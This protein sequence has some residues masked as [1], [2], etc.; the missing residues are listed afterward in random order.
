M[1]RQVPRQGL[2]EL[3]RLARSQ[4][5]RRGDIFAQPGERLPGLLAVV[6]G[7]VKLALRGERGE[8][9]ILRLVGPANTLARRCC[10]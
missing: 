1:F 4:E 9:R 7:L 10:S 2:A 5:L 3:M 8:E 6:Y